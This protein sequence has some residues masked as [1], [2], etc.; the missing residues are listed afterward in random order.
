M[1]LRRWLIGAC[2]GLMAV[3]GCKDEEKPPTETLGNG[4]IGNIKPAAHDEAAF[5]APL[6]AT[7]SPDGSKVYFTARNADGAGVFTASAS[8]GGTTALH[9]GDPIAGPVGITVSTDDRMVYVADP[10]AEVTEEQKGAIWMVPTEGGT[11]TAVSG[12]AG[13]SPSGIVLVNENGAD[14][15]YFTGRVPGEDTPGVFKVAAAGGTVEGLVKGEPFSDPN[16]IAVAKNGS[17]YVLDSAAGDLSVGSARVIQVVD[18]SA[19]VLAEGLMVGFPA[20]IALS[21]DETVVLLSAL[22]PA[23]RTDTVV[24]IDVAT[25]EQKSMSDG[26]NTYEEAAGLHRAANAEVYAWADSSADGS[27]TVYVLTP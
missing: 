19:S 21:Q 4:T 7:P 15:L 2:L 20:G 14:Q 13:Y 24:R 5:T 23:T 9:A 16:G 18:Q 26:I 3:T 27:G 11:P 22:D 10:A 1:P 6:D 25:K 8:G 17:I 12:T